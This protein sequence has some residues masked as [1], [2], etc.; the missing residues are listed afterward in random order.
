MPMHF[1]WNH[2]SHSSHSTMSSY[3]SGIRHV[4]KSS[5]CTYGK[6]GGVRRGIETLFCGNASNFRFSK[7][8]RRWGRICDCSKRIFC[9][10]SPNATWSANATANTPSHK[11]HAAV[12]PL[13]S[14]PPALA[15]DQI[16]HLHPCHWLD[17]CKSEQAGEWAMGE[18]VHCT[19]CR[20]EP[21]PSRKSL[22]LPNGFQQQNGFEGPRAAVLRMHPSPKGQ[23]SAGHRCG[24]TGLSADSVQDSCA[25]LW[26]TFPF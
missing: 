23:W 12:A 10:S 3:V 19:C 24:G 16:H 25:H 6:K 7:H 1:K 11:L 14:W 21:L 2:C 18:V 13:G 17:S 15:M 26:A 9:G 20:R 5:M 8:L 22:M 4:Q